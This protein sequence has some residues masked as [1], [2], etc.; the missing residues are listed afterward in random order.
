MN[1]LQAIIKDRL[2]KFFVTEETLLKENEELLKK[3]GY[4]EETKSCV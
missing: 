2:R 3:A 4:F 1:R